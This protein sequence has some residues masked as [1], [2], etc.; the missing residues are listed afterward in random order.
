MDK[1]DIVEWV[2]NRFGIQLLEP[3]KNL[4]RYAISNDRI[5][6][7]PWPRHGQTFTLAIIDAYNEIFKKENEQ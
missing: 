6:I 7:Y 5:V 4:L 3:Q 1:P 2:E